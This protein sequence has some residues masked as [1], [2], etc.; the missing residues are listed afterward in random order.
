MENTNNENTQ[1]I[2]TNNQKQF[3]EQFCNSCGKAIKIKAE[4]CPYCGVRQKSDSESS[5]KSW[6]TLFILYLFLG[7]IGVH[8]FY[9]GR[10]V[11]GVFYILTLNGIGIWAIIDFILIIT[12]NFKDSNGKLINK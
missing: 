7:W 4:V 8:R 9:S 1:E 10:V 3:D 11:S 5:E 6:V 12:K 2:S